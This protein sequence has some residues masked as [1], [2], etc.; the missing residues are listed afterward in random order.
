MVEKKSSFIDSV[1]RVMSWMLAGVA[2]GIALEAKKAD[3]FVAS[4]VLI[5]LGLF[6]LAFSD[7]FMRNRYWKR[8]ADL[9]N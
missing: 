5:F 3:S 1:I 9:I 8:I 2:A 6:I 7:W 4:F